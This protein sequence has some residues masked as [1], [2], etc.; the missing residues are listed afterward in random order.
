[1]SYSFV[2]RTCLECIRMTNHHWTNFGRGHGFIYTPSTW[3]SK[4]KYL[5]CCLTKTYLLSISVQMLKM[6]PSNNFFIYL[7]MTTVDFQLTTV[8]HQI[9][10]LHKLQKKKK[11]QNILLILLYIRGRFANYEEELFKVES[12]SICITVSIN[13]FKRSTL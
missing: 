5:M 6:C 13:R 3:V 8:D 10:C 2:L 1:M 4:R 7:Q 9:F 12:N 11:I